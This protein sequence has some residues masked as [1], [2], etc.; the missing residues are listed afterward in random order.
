LLLDGAA[1]ELD[2]TEATDLIVL[3]A[4]DMRIAARVRRYGYFERHGYEFTLRAKRNTG[5][6]T[7][8][9]KIVEGWGD[10]LFYGHADQAETIIAHWMIVDLHAFR[11][12][13]IRRAANGARVLC[14][15]KS[16]GDGTQFKW[17]DVRSFPSHPPILIAANHRPDLLEGAA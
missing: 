14:G 8:L 4:R 6:K 16:N 11:A 13:L 15:D 10:W 12:A 1:P 17:F 3:H 5:A 9:S 2:R 7:E